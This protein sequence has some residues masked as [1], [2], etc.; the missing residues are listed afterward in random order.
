MEREG[1]MPNSQNK[2]QWQL[3]IPKLQKR[4]LYQ[5]GFHGPCAIK[6]VLPTIS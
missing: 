1:Q 4:E 6:Y 5:E 3:N 2:L